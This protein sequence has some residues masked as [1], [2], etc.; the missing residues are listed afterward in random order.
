MSIGIGVFQRIVLTV[1]VEIL[2]SFVDRADPNQQTVASGLVNRPWGP[3]ITGKKKS[4]PVSTSRSLLVKL[5]ETPHRAPK[6][7]EVP[8]K[9]VERLLRSAGMCSPKGGSR[10]AI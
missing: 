8:H 4:K 6:Q 10:T 2:S 1:A 5:Y 9:Q 3:V 7:E